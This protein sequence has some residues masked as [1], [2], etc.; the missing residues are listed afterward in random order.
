MDFREICS[1]F[2]GSIFYEEFRCDF[3]YDDISSR[4]EALERAEHVEE[5]DHTA[6][7]SLLRAIA[8]ILRGQFNGAET[9]LASLLHIEDERWKARAAF[10]AMFCWTTKLY[11]PLFRFQPRCESPTKIL[12]INCHSW[13]GE[14]GE[15]TT[16]FALAHVLRRLNPETVQD[17]DFLEKTLFKLIWEVHHTGFRTAQLLNPQYCEN[18]YQS[19][20]GF[21]DGFFNLVYLREALERLAHHFSTLG[22]PVIANYISRLLY[23]LDLMGGAED[24]KESLANLRTLNDSEGDSI[25]VGLCDLLEGD[26]ILSGPFSSPLALNI[27]L[28]EGWMAGP[29]GDAEGSLP[30]LLRTKY[31]GSLPVEE[32]EHTVEDA[33]AKLYRTFKAFRVTEMR[34][35]LVES[36]SGRKYV[37][38]HV[39]RERLEASKASALSRPRRNFILRRVRKVFAKISPNYLPS[40]HTRQSRA[41]LL[42]RLVLRKCSKVVS[43]LVPIAAMASQTE[44]REKTSFEG[45]GEL[46]FISKE[47]YEQ[48]EECY[49]RAEQRFKSTNSARGVAAVSMRRACIEIMQAM[50]Q[51]SPAL[52]PPLEETKKLLTEASTILENS[53]D[54]VGRAF[55]DLLRFLASHERREIFENVVLIGRI[56]G[57]NGAEIFAQN[58][59]LLALRFGDFLDIAVDIFREQRWVIWRATISHNHW[60]GTRKHLGCCC[61]LLV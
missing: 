21:D 3:S 48:A 29:C 47:A 52:N 55:C 42:L 13:P 31:D 11:H 14:E 6:A 51:L 57:A 54:V 32:A 45:Q 15:T 20:R 50:G 19:G 8:A 40:T 30:S 1:F 18:H 7:N 25:G 56:A 17:L 37:G 35:E 59:A 10:Y 4:I 41:P 23:E 28:V 16:T 22:L 58:L 38:A 27:P 60:P 49:S 24:T 34:V 2:G 12:N 26:C 9:I 53:L 39:T 44:T 61:C 43:T 36:A 5:S 33:N 46:V